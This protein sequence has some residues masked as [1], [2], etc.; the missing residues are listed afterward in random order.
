MWPEW[1]TGGFGSAISHVIG[2]F[3]SSFMAFPPFQEYFF[4][5]NFI[6]AHFTFFCVHAKIKYT[7]QKEAAY[8][9]NHS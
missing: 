5:K 7:H 3:S 4:R 8:V 6:Y 9:P 1:I 2:F